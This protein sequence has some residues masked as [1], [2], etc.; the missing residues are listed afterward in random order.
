MTNQIISAA[1]YNNLQARV[2]NLLGVGGGNIGYNQAVASSQVADEAIVTALEMNQIY[3]DLVK[4]R[5]HQNGS[6]PTGIIKE[7][8]DNTTP[9]LIT[10]GT[11]I[12]TSNNNVVTIVTSTDHKLI[13]GVYV[14]TITGVVGM[15]QLNNQFGFAKVLSTT[16]F[17]LYQN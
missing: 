4:I 17:E 16:S 2:G 10:T 9:T 14:D 15:T 6:E 13:D 11:F 12:N 1:R 7:V 8:N 5:T 3:S